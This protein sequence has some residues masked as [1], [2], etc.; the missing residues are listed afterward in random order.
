MTGGAAEL[1]R[2]PEDPQR[3][4]FL[5]LFFDLVFVLALS[6]LSQG[7]LE[8]LSWSEAFRTLVLRLAL[9]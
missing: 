2:R 5:E 1:R 7:L 3:A 9:P 4:T 6:R 8:H